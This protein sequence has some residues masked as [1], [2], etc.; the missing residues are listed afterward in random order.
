MNPIAQLGPLCIRETLHAAE[1]HT[2]AALLEHYLHL[3]VI[4][5]LLGAVLLSTLGASDVERAFGFKVSSASGAF[6][7]WAVRLFS[8][9]DLVCLDLQRHLKSE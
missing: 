1:I 7:R 6:A 3:N 2:V 9:D 8:Y 5:A 4:G